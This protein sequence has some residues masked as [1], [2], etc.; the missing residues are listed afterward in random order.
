MPLDTFGYYLYKLIMAPIVYKKQGQILDF[1]KQHIQT[2]GTAPTLKQIAD[3]I[4]VSSL[5]TDHENL[6]SL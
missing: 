6:T 2:Y 4:G 5:A 3:A 1:I